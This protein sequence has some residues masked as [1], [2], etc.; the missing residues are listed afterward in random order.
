MKH[1][2]IFNL[3]NDANNSKFLTAKWNIV[4]YNSNLN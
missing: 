4:N 3:L 1:Q 2:K